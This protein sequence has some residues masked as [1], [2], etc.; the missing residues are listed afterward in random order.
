MKK[1]V[2]IMMIAIVSLCFVPEMVKAQDSTSSNSE[3][4][5]INL[6]VQGI[7][8]VSGTCRRGIF[9]GFGGNLKSEDGHSFPETSLF[10]S[11]GIPVGRGQM[12]SFGATCITYP[13]EHR[14]ARNDHREARFGKHFGF[15][16]DIGYYYQCDVNVSSYF[17]LGAPLIDVFKDAGMNWNTRYWVFSP[18]VEITVPIGEKIR[19]G[20]RINVI[21]AMWDFFPQSK[22]Y[23]HAKQWYDMDN[24]LYVSYNFGST[25]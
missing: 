12:T 9:V 3:G 20:S 10:G 21:Y 17:K 16:F 15:G 7:G 4:S 25:E 2:I 6:K 19:V 18:L 14:G 24:F 22:G 8:R 23:S 11:F 13:M 1:L 5:S